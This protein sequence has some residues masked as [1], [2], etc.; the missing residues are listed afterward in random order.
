[1]SPSEIEA[2]LVEH[3]A[4]LEAGVV[5]VADGEG[6][7]RPHAFVVLKPG[8]TA[9]SDL[10]TTLTEFVHKRGG[11]RTPATVAFV[12][13]LPKTATGKVQRFRLRGA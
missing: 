9:S 6:L 12:D 13:D 5:G 2:Q 3:P 8:W 11:L 7:T 4:V 1:V 10:A